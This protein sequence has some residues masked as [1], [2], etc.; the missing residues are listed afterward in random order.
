MHAAGSDRVKDVDSSLSGTE[1]LWESEASTPHG[2]FS[3]SPQAAT[4]T[5]FLR[6]EALWSLGISRYRMC[7]GGSFGCYSL[8]VN[9]RASTPSGNYSNQAQPV[10]GTALR[11]ISPCIPQT[12]WGRG[13]C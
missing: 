10:L 4:V 9:P 6:F 2:P 13:L 11:F 1:G 5:S 8:S 3:L 12:L 7:G